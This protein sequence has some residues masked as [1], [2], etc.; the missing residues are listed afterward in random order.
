MA[1]SRPSGAKR[2]SDGNGKLLLSENNI[3]SAKEWNAESLPIRPGQVDVT[4]ARKMLND[5]FSVG[6]VIFDSGI[7]H[8]WEIEE[9]YDA[10]QVNGRLS[11]LNMAIS[12]VNSP[13]EIWDQGEQLSFVQAFRKTTGGR[14]GVAVFVNKKTQKVKTY[15]PKDIAALDKV[16]KGEQIK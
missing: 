12:A 4:V 15:F 5:G 2:R 7:L 8:H 10:K 13:R 1:K 14:S 6:N 11:K 3:T 9:K 16:R